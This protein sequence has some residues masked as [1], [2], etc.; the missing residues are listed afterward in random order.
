MKRVLFAGAAALASAC[1]A[2]P[3]VVAAALP[4]TQ[5]TKPVCHR[6]LLPVA[7]RIA[8]TAV[9]RP[10]NGTMGMEVQFELQ[11]A[12]HRFGPFAAVHG[13][14]LEQW[15]H[16]DNPTLGQR[17]GDIWR[18]DQ[19]VENLPGTAFYRFRVR[20]RWT[21]AHG[22]SLGTS[23]AIG[24]LC[25]EPELRPDLLVRSLTVRAAPAQPA[26][27]QSATS[28]PP[29]DHYIAVIANRGRTGAGPFDVE[30][31]LPAR[32]PQTLAV[33]GL[34]SHSSAHETFTAPACTAG[35]RVTVIV[36][37]NAAILDYDRANNTLTVPCPTSATQARRY[38]R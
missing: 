10:V 19:K 11:R 14:G 24:P 38:T 29:Q 6:A 18:V 28:Q 7:R 32:P 5:L 4:S 17:P 15:V 33:T 37:P 1:L 27:G 2:A 36:D 16:P 35:G 12:R 22:R 30:L 26:S 8:I 31:I 9:M 25:Y 20:F 21:G 23:S 34:G 13:R 3:V